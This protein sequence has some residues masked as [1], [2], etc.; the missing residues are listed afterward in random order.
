MNRPL[1]KK[2][3]FIALASI[4]TYILFFNIKNKVFTYSN[5]NIIFDFVTS[6]FSNTYFSGTLCSILTVIIIYLVQVKYS[7]KVKKDFRCNEIMQDIFL[8]INNYSK[9]K[10]TIPKTKKINNDNILFIFGIFKCRKNL[11]L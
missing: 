6:L 5:S 2:A 8:R 7:K 4:I 9:I 11:Y 1:F 3:L 10:S